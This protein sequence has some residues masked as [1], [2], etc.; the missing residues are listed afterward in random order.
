VV[1]KN[2]SRAEILAE[3]VAPQTP[4]EAPQGASAPTQP[5][6]TTAAVPG[7][8]PAAAPPPQSPVTGATPQTGVTQVAEGAAADRLAPVVTYADADL[9]SLADIIRKSV[10]EVSQKYVLV[11]DV[12]ITKSVIP[13]YVQKAI[14]EKLEQ[15][16]LAKAQQYRLE[17]VE[18][19]QRIKRVEAVNNDIISRSLT[20][21]LLTMKGI[22]ATK[23]LATSPNSK[24][25]VIGSGQGGL[26]VILNT[27]R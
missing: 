4:A 2:V 13:D 18:T 15:K 24:V 7:Q 3:G 17:Q 25:I 23:E 14:Q 6:A 1:N 11:D 12:I 16:E 21:P 26:P 10:R 19:E 20:T 22:E 8:A 5:E 27:E 9:S